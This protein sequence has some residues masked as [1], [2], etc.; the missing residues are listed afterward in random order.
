MMHV[1][2]FRLG[3]ARLLVVPYIKTLIPAFIGVMG[4]SALVEMVFHFRHAATG[5]NE[6][7]VFWTTFD[8]HTILPW[9]VALAITIV[10]LGITRATAPALREAWND[11][12]TANGGQ[13]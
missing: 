12:N 4:L 8:S 11:A 7:T 3:R 5:D 9:L 13:Q 6:M 10:S 2:V 1:P